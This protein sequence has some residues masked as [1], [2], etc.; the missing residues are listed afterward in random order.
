MF[1][2]AARFSKNTYEKDEAVRA[3]AA[4]VIDH[5]EQLALDVGLAPEENV[6]LT[7]AGKEIRIGVSEYFDEY[8]REAPGEWRS[9]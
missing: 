9:Y 5:L 2:T 6:A 7:D 1:I 4:R 3:K 8:L